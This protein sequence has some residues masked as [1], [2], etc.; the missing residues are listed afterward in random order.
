[1]SD[2]DLDYAMACDQQ[3][4]YEFTDLVARQDEAISTLR[5]QVEV[6]RGALIEGVNWG[7]DD[8]VDAVI[9]FR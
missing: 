3:A 8:K 9:P 6:L 7:L 5:E 2:K 4:I 1:M